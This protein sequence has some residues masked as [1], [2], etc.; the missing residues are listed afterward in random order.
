MV[1][2]LMSEKKI[3]VLEYGWLAVQE[4]K[5]EKSI[6]AEDSLAGLMMSNRNEQFNDAYIASELLDHLVSL[7]IAQLGANRADCRK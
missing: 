2:V 5:K 4:V 7:Q 1:N 6:Q 3:G